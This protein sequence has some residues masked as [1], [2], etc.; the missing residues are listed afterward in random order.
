[1]TLPQPYSQRDAR[2]ANHEL[3]G[4][5]LRMG[6]YGCVVTACAYDIS[7]ALGYEVLPV[8]FLD[9]LND[10]Q[11]FTGGG[12]LYWKKVDEYTKG[13]LRYTTSPFLKRFTLVQG[14]MGRYLHWVAMVPNKLVFDPWTGTLRT[15]DRTWFRPTGRKVYFR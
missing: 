13:R 3:N 11:G 4:S 7:R 6:E 15:I 1:M 9:W 2:W 10:H 8:T 12:L 5:G 14:A